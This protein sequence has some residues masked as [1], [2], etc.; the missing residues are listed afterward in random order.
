MRRWEVICVFFFRHKFYVRL[1]YMKTKTSLVKPKNVLKAS[2]KISALVE[3]VSQEF[4]KVDLESLKTDPNI[5][6]YVGK[7]I[8]SEFGKKINVKERVIEIIAKVIPLTE[9]EIEAIGRIY[10][11]LEQ[12]GKIVAPTVKLQAYNW[13]KNFLAKK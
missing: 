2:L 4:G 11:Y 6:E 12:E 8:V 7:L 9:Q 5:I 10:D 3:K 13:A 1:K